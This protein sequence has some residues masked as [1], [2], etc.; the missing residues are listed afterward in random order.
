MNGLSEFQSFA[1]LVFEYRAEANLTQQEVADIVGVDR[2]TEVRWEHGKAMPCAANVRTLAKVLNIPKQLIKPFLMKN[3][4]M[5]QTVVP[6][7]CDPEN[8][9]KR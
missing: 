1:D 9:P 6:G 4:I 3:R 5:H 2:S 7:D 8:S